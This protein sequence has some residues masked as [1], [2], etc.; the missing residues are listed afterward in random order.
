MEKYLSALT[1]Y[2]PIGGDV[3][4]ESEGSTVIVRVQEGCKSLYVAVT[5][6][7]AAGIVTVVELEL[8]SAMYCVSPVHLSKVLSEVGVSAEMGTT[9]STA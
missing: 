9:V 2:A 4:P 6:T 1:V 7:S 8:T 3:I 5:M